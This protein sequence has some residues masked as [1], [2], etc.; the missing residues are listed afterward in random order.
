M[1]EFIKGEDLD[2][3]EPKC[4]LWADASMRRLNDKKEVKEKEELPVIQ[5]ENPLFE[6][7]LENI[8]F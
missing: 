6:E 7:P 1:Q 5:Q 8:T 3:A 2:I 4:E